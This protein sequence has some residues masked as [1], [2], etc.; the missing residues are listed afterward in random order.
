MPFGPTFIKASEVGLS[1]IPFS[2]FYKDS[3]G[4]IWRAAKLYDT[5]W[6]KPYGYEKLPELEFDDLI[7]LVLF[8]DYNQLSM[9]TRDVESNQYGAASVIM[10]RYITEFIDFM[11]D[12][13]YNDIIFND[14]LCIKNLRIFAFN[15][16]TLGIRIT[17]GSCLYDSILSKYPSWNLI[18]SE[19][20]RRVYK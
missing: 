18:A 6:G 14:P 5:G 16:P 17:N 1:R 19:M 15:R 9:R 13:I 2:S 4:E 8:S 11:S 10:D 3:N 20:I 12:N 7:T